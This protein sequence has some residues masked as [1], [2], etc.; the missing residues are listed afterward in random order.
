MF[1]ETGQT[2]SINHNIYVTETPKTLIVEIYTPFTAFKYL[3]TLLVLLTRR[4][5][6]VLCSRLSQP[7]RDFTR[8]HSLGKVCGSVFSKEALLMET[9]CLFKQIIWL[10][11]VFSTNNCTLWSYMGYIVSIYIVKM[12]VRFFSWRC[13]APS[14]V[15]LYFMYIVAKIIHATFKNPSLLLSTVLQ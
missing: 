13:S 14:S 15:Y 2:E 3:F 6:S 11:L 7:S 1:N 9:V 12:G 8:S 10:K 5:L 4:H